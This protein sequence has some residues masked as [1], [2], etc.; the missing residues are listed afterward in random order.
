[1][2]NKKLFSLVVATSMV[3][4]TAFGGFTKNAKADESKKDMITVYVAAEGK[5]ASGAAVTIPKTPLRLN[6]GAKASTAIKEV[7]N[8]SEYANNY[9]ISSSSW[10]ESLDEINGLNT[11]NVG[12]DWYFWGFYV[13]GNYSN[14]GI[15]NYELKNNDK[16]SLIYNYD[17]FNMETSDFKDDASKNPTGAALTL[18]TENAKKA[19][20]TL[21]ET[22]F[23]TTFDGGKKVPGIEDVNGLYTVFSLARAGF[24][25]DSFYDDVY[26]KINAQLCTLHMTGKVYDETND[27]YITEKNIIKDGYASQTYAKIALCV[28]AIGRDASD[29]GGFNLIDKLADKS[30]YNASS[31][32]SRESMILFAL[33]TAAASIPEGDNYL[34]RA[35]LINTLVDDVDNQIDTAILWG[36]IDSAA[37][38]IQPLAPYVKKEVPNVSKAAVTLACEKALKFIETM[39][40][41]DGTY[42]DSYS[43][44]NVWTLSQ[45]MITAG[46]FGCDTLSER[47]GSD[48]IK[49]GKT[50]FDA[51]GSFI[52]VTDKAV[53][54]NLMSF[55]P[56]QLL[57]G[58][59]SCIRSADNQNSLFDAGDITYKAAEPKRVAVTS[60]MVS[61]ISD[62]SYTGK[63]VA[64][65]VTVK[66][67][68]K[69]L[70]QGKDYTVTYKNNKKPGT[71]TVIIT[72]KGDYILSCKVTFKIKLAKTV[73]AKV[74]PGK[75][76]VTVN[77]KKTAGAKKYR[78]EVST[79]K[80]FKKAKSTMV[81]NTSSLSVKFTGLKS[82]K[83][84]YVRAMAYNGN[85]KGAYS[86][87]VAVK[88]K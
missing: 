18:I 4:T 10:G 14:Y 38:A 43:S 66:K 57:R 71:A 32:Y 24:K 31:I 22:I 80:N 61:Q 63:A 46:L 77:I 20:E 60:D 30:V 44:N 13:N 50:L 51:A 27:T 70:V 26:E 64:P 83:K 16:I 49:N 85:Y 47:D 79:D 67:D 69:K 72:G 55:Q 21:A 2:K 82:S 48:F 42:G 23:N 17:N 25:A 52:N 11:Y 56:E 41:A 9:V 87:T 8:G 34:T 40:S 78:V 88:V 74:T 35:E 5:N 7:L 36:S 6:E 84:Y 1:M 12:S 15:S 62:K 86:R 54:E 33:D 3:I 58:L 75:K 68:G 37:M 81:K 28:E 45:V 29:I 19:Q 73:I 65:F 59:N 76:K 53:D 39:Q